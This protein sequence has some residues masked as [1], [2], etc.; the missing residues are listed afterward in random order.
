MTTLDPYRTD[1]LAA[2]EER[3]WGT[4][5]STLNMVFDADAG[6]AADY[7]RSLSDAPPLQRALALHDEPLDVASALTGK[8]VTA[9]RV[10]SYEAMRYLFSD[11]VDASRAAPERRP[12]PDDILSST[13]RDES[14][15]MVSVKSLNRLMEELGY[16]RLTVEAGIAFFALERKAWKKPLLKR[17]NME[18]L[19]GL[20]ADREAVY[21]LDRVVNMLDA[22]AEYARRRN[23][24][25]TI[26][27]RIEKMKM[28]LLRTLQ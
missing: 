15:P 13:R 28:R 1:E 18:S 21:R 9:E 20:D 27:S 5:A 23:P 6:L 2:L 3:Y 16:R 14:A 7:R 4:L 26:V 8:P 19:P 22:L 17:Y 11:P 12:Q 24:A 10:A 25:S